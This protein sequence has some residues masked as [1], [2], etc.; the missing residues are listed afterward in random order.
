MVT[1]SLQN[2]ICVMRIC[3]HLLNQ[4]PIS[5]KLSMNIIPL[6]AISIYFCICFKVN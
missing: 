6:E 1:P 2:Y 3:L 4:W 5:M